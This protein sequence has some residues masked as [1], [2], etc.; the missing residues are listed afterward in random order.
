[1][2]ISI[3]VLPSGYYHI[4]GTGPCNWAQ[5]PF[6]PCDE[7]CVRRHAFPEASEEFILSAA[8]RA[9]AERDLKI[10]PD[11]FGLA[12]GNCCGK[13]QKQQGGKDKYK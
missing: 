3:H 7:A 6:W 13:R 4:R 9:T 11:L 8:R 12:R 1:M 5:V 10:I 2:K